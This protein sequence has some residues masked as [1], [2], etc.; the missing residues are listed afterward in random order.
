MLFQ[1][2]PQPPD[3]VQSALSPVQVRSPVAPIEF[4]KVPNTK[5][6]FGFVDMTVKPLGRTYNWFGR[7][8]QSIWP[9]PRFADI[10]ARRISHVAIIAL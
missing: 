7:N 9:S 8:T 1:S 6:P 5:I 4:V 2:V 10:E 3:V